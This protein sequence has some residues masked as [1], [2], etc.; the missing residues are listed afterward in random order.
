MTAGRD[1]QITLFS[2]AE[3]CFNVFGIDVNLAVEVMNMV[4]IIT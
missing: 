3:R 2:V 1:T 4:L